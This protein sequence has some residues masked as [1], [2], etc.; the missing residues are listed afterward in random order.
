MQPVPVVQL[1]HVSKAVGDALPLQ[2]VSLEVGQGELLAITGV[3]GAGKTTLLGIL[4]LLEEAS[5]GRYLLQGRL[6]SELG[7]AERARIRNQLFGFVFQQFSLIPNLTAWQNVARPLNYAGFSK[8]DQKARALEVLADFG[9]SKLAERR[10]AQLSGGEQQRVAIARA[11]I[12]NPALVLADEPTGN[13]PVEQWEPIFDDLEALRSAGKTIIIATHYPEV[14]ERASRVLQL[15]AGR[16]SPPSTYKLDTRSSQAQQSLPDLQLSFLNEPHV[17]RKGEVIPAT[18]RQLELLALLAAHPA[19]LT[20]EQLLLL[21]YG[22]NGKAGTLKSALS[23]LRPV[24]AVASRPYRIDEPFVADFITV[25]ELLKTGAIAEAVDSYMAPLLPA[26]S[27][28]GII[29]IRE[30][31][32]ESI[33]QAVILS[34]DP[35]LL[36]VLAE[37]LAEDLELWELAAEAMPKEDTRHALALMHVEQIRKRWA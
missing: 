36:F 2:D 24:A 32:D 21:A 12:N 1:E 23:R 25:A 13:L 27:A 31:L 14:A 11:L 34:A 35:E 20:G 17:Q 7:D 9:L 5:G 30:H 8:R 16:L 37:R 19:G 6:V 4:G 15:S 22:E 28:P 3:S 33:R 26:S 10:P 29:E 18:P